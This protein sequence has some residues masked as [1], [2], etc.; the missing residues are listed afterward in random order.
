MTLT[1]PTPFS[2]IVGRL[3]IS[4]HSKVS[5]FAFQVFS[6]QNI[7]CSQITMNYLEKKWMKIVAN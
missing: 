4:G 5:D 3:N 1:Y 6:N 7:S 2:V